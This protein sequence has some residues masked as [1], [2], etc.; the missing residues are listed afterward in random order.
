[1]IKRLLFPVSESIR[2]SYRDFSPLQ[3][4]VDPITT[5]PLKGLTPL[6]E[7]TI[8]ISSLYEEGQSEPLTGAFTTGKQ[9]LLW[10]ETFPESNSIETTQWSSFLPWLGGSV[11]WSV[12]LYTKRLQVQ[13]LVGAHTWVAG[14]IPGEGTY[15]REANDVSHIDISFSLSLSSLPLSLKYQ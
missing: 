9:A 15:G 5:F 1:M 7:Y 10:C 4:E 3:V 14:L 12:V 11:G 2:Y 13:F 6:T 8:A